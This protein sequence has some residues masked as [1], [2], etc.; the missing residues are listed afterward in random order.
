MLSVPCSTAEMKDFVSGG[1][2]SLSNA[3]YGDDGDMILSGDT[4]SQWRQEYERRVKKEV[5]SVFLFISLVNL[6]SDVLFL[7]ER[8]SVAEKRMPDCLIAG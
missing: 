7:E 5:I 4:V 1:Y 3:F 2:F 6:L 8:E